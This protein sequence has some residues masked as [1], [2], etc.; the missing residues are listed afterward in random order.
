M[1]SIEAAIDGHVATIT[2]NRPE[3]LNAISGE[4]ADLLAGTLLQAAARADVWVAVLAAAG[5]KAFCV[6]ADLKERNRL[7]DSGWLRNR[8]LMRGMFDSL[9]AVPQPTIA[10]V[11]GHALG[12][13]FELALS[14]DLIVA[15]EDAMFGLPEVRV[16][17]LPGGGG[18]QLLARKIGVARAKELVLTARRITAPEA[19]RMGLVGRVV[20]RADLAAATDDLAAEICRGAPVS[21]RESKRVIDRGFDLPLDDALELEDLAWR[22]TVASEDRREGIAAFN[23]KRGPEWKGR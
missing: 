18:T 13:G 15:S 19:H 4:M 22:R 3:A 20:P 14:C 16:G 21:V 2:L 23:E 17:I 5:P 9:R 8:I 11:F 1:S 7:D 6:G 12:G 10:S